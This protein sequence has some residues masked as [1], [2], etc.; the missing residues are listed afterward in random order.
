MNYENPKY[1]KHGTI[2]CILDHP[3]LGK[4]PFTADPNDP[5]RLGREVYSA[6]VK[7]D[8]AL[9]YTEEER[10]ADLEA[11][12]KS[13]RERMLLTK[14]QMVKSLKHHTLY[15][16]VKTAM[17]NNPDSDGA[18]AYE[19]SPD[20]KRIGVFSQFIQQQLNLTDEELD[21]IFIKGGEFIG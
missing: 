13:E 9:P 7:N 3:K 11:D 12:L 16:R 5:E 6:I 1:N 4:I 8:D 15:D 19:T 10:Q 17:G 21:N 2:D 18:L 14:Y 20:F